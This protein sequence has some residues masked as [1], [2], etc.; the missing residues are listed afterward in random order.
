MPAD[1]AALELSGG[2]PAVRL[3]DGSVLHGRTIIIAT[4]AR[5][6]TLQVP[7]LARFEPIAVYYAATPVEA[8]LCRN[9]PVAVV[10]SGNS[11]GQA[12]LFL[13][14][15]AAHLSLLIRGTDLAA[16]MSRY[17]ADRIERDTRIDVLRS[18]EVRELGGS[19]SLDWLEVEDTRT[20]G[21]RRVDAR[22]LFVFIGA[23]PSTRW[24]GSQVALDES[25]FIR[26][27]A[28]LAHPGAHASPPEHTPS[29]LETSSRGVFAA[30]DVRSGSVKR[31]AA[32]VGEGAMAVRFVHDQISGTLAG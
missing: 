8:R 18:T 21:R 5:Y 2:P 17:L 6:R 1:A 11:A 25:G 24:L 12:A 22:A 28:D 15:H 23:E 20:G 32:A 29:R 4:G 10:G 19:D 27:G 13:A 3:A 16:T 9:L 14:D 26:T 7:G 30:G 31:V